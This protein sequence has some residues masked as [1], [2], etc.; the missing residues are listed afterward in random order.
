MA[1][2]FLGAIDYDEGIEFKADLTEKEFNDMAKYCALDCYY[3][4]KLYDF[5]K[6]E[7]QEDGKLW[8][9]FKY[10]V[11]P[12]ERILQD[13]EDKGAYIDQEKLDEVLTKYKEER[14]LLDVEINKLL[15]DKWKD[16]INLNSPKQLGELLFEDLKL[17]VIERTATGGYSTGKSVLLR[18]VDKHPLPRLI[19]DRRKY[20]KAM[21]GF[22]LPW[23]DFLKRDGRLHST[24]KIA[25]TTTGRLSAENPNLQ[26][27][28]RD[29]NVRS[30]VC[31]PNGKVFIEADYSQIELRTASFVANAT[32]MKECY[33]RGEDLHTKTA[34]SVSHV[35]MSEVTK[36]QR[37][38]AKAVNFGFLYGMWWKSFKAYA[39]DSYG[40]VVTDEEAEHAR[41]VYFK[42]YPELLDW[43]ERQKE[44]V[45]KH[46][47]VRTF[48]G[49]LRHLPNIDSPDKD[50]R[51]KAE[52]QA[53]NTVVQSP[54]S[55]MT[56]LAMILIDKNLK[57]II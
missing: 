31:A 55:D 25:E 47:C 11:M 24:Y 28:P 18:L 49:R 30:L 56:L 8:R 45:R 23:K 17:P 39:F 15:P 3:T 38:S 54:A 32:S 19:L 6:K 57:K 40:V 21:N 13:I 4:L 14:D 9:V 33:K 22:L 51:G 52:R 10:I 7:L 12:G 5:T 44:Y 2:T 27:V 37:T 29:S 36:T 20:E 42:T 43:H 46:K 34:A 35:P 53:I 50:L 1:K 41:N 16:T 26:Q 48:M